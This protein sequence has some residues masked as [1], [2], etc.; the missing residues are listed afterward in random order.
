MAE[1]SQVSALLDRI[2][3]D[4]APA[5]RRD[6]HRRGSSTTACWTGSG[7]D[8]LASVLAAKAAGAAHLDELT[9]DADLE[10]FVLFSSAAATFGGGGQGN[11]AAANA[12]LDGL[13]QQPAARGLAGALAGLG[14]LGGRRRGR[15]QPGGPAAAAPRPAA[16]DGPGPV[17]QGAGRRRWTGRTGCSG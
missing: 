5:D 10:Q 15:G 8:R 4:R 16:R 1:R 11:Y 13:A 2:A 12:F 6:A 17:H 9:R 7:P 3:A 14:S